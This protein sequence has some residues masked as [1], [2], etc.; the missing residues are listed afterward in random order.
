[1]MTEYRLS[2]ND[3]IAKGFLNIKDNSLSFFL[4]DEF[5]QGNHDV[6]TLET[7]NDVFI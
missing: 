7:K 5:L 6:G 4:E 3:P 1:M 2:K